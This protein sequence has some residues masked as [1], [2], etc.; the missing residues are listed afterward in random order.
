MI[1]NTG[2]RTDT[3]NYYGDW[4]LNRFKEGFV[5]SRNP[6]YPDQVY[7]YILS[8][9]VVDCVV[10]CSKNYE[11]ILSRFYEIYDRFNVFCFYTITAYGEDIEPKVPDI[12]TSMST[13]IKLSSL[14]GK[15]KVAWRYDPVLLTDKYTV[16]SHLKTFDCMAEK[17][18]PY[19][20]LCIFSFVEMYK[21]LEKNMPE[22][23]P[24]TSE[25]K[26]QILEGFGETSK[27][28]NLKIQTCADSEDYSKYGICTSGCI[29]ADILSGSLGVKFKKL[30]HNGNRKNCRCMPSR[31]IGAY[32]TCLNG[33][34]Y[35]YANSDPA[36]AFKNFPKHN[37][38][39]PIMLGN[40]SEQ[41]VI[42]D[43]KQESFIEPQQ[44]LFKNFSAI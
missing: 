27:K 6:F 15:E 20:K 39:S 41:D 11:P 16:E 38:N 33:C 24:F 7:K 32:N 13:L 1:I 40:I 2:G 3:V 22:I 26:K 21:K 9:D 12:E 37:P 4:L 43:G 34:K 25:T 31:D 30:P 10:F 17:L 29:T 5:Y 35:C 19:V 44:S 18:A 8:P 14:V 42:I 28:Y 23:I 36:V